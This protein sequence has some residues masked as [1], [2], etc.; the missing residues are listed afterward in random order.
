MGKYDDVDDCFASNSFI[1]EEYRE[2]KISLTVSDNM[3]MRSIALIFFI[4]YYFWLDMVYIGED[5]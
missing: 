4:S 2:Y 5:N 3:K 1:F